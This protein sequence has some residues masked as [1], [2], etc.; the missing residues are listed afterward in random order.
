[1]NV[2]EEKG[3]HIFQ[4]LLKIQRETA[5]IGMSASFEDKKVEE[6]KKLGFKMTMTKTFDEELLAK[7]LSEV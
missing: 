3:E 2:G 6:L 5:V 4:Q 7:I 1:M